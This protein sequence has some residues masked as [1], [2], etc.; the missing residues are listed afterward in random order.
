MSNIRGYDLFL[1]DTDGDESGYVGEG[2]MAVDALTLR[3]VPALTLEAIRTDLEALGHT[4]RAVTITSEAHPSEDDPAVAESIPYRVADADTGET[5]LELT[6]WHQ[7]ITKLAAA[8]V[9][10]A[11]MASASKGEA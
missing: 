6:V 10:R 8:L 11:T 7:E 1:Y 4:P 9:E 2:H 3:P 5:L